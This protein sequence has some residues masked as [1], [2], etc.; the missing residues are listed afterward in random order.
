MSKYVDGAEL[1]CSN[2]V[3]LDVL[4][5]ASCAV[6]SSFQTSYYLYPEGCASIDYYQ[7]LADIAE[8]GMQESENRILVRS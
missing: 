3:S 4:I 7:L 6:V 2:V 8:F 5:E 1:D